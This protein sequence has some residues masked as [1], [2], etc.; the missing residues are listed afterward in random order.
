[1]A[2]FVAFG[3]VPVIFVPARVVIQEGLAY[4]P[5]EYTPFVTVVAFV[6]L[7]AFVAKSAFAAAIDD[8]TDHS[9]AAPRYL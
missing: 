5:V 4:D 1:M 9:L 8:G 7:V 6:A 2:A 3:T